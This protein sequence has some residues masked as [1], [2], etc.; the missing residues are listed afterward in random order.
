MLAFTCGDP[1]GVGPEIIARWLAEHP[2]EAKGVAVIG[3]ESWI[4]TLPGAGAR[5]VLGDGAFV[6]RPGRPTPEGAKTS[7]IT[8][9]RPELVGR[10]KR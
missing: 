6:A 5:F 3:A 4:E 9:P 1:A 8:F 10:T 2:N 7:N